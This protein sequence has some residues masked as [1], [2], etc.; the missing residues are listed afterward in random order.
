MLSNYDDDVI[1]ASM[2]FHSGW[3]PDSL[4]PRLQICY[5]LP[6]DTITARITTAGE[7]LS[8]RLYPNPA[9]NALTL[10]VRSSKPQAGAV[11]LYDLQGRLLQVLKSD[12]PLAA[13]NNI[14]HSAIDRHN[15]P[16]GLYFVKVQLGNTM[17]TYKV[18]LR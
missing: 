5:S 7:P 18:T 13:G 10:Q 12:V 16:A 11:F 3:A 1:S 6:G 17:H 2:V 9:T 14:I 8:L 15:V 4:Q